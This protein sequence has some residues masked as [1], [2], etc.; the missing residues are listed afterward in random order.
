MKN[1]TVLR[2]DCNQFTKLTYDNFGQFVQ[3]LS[4]LHHVSLS[5]NPIVGEIDME[6]IFGGQQKGEM[7]FDLAHCTSVTN[8]INIPKMRGFDISFSSIR[9]VQQL[10]F[11]NETS[12]NIK[13][14]WVDEKQMEIFKEFAS[15]NDIQLSQMWKTNVYNG[16]YNI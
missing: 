14:L 5:K 1:V 9:S 13:Q 4:K 15:H 10:R 11:L 3:V 8:I 2:F 16:S 6:Q 7:V 12:T